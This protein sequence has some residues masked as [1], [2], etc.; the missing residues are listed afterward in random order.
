MLLD[1]SYTCP[2]CRGAF[3]KIEE[4]PEAN[5]EQSETGD[6]TASS[7]GLISRFKSVVCLNVYTLYKKIVGPPL[8][9]NV[10]EMNT[11]S[12]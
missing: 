12:A 5:I 4:E 6:D 7:E 1:F 8:S 3:M 2:M 10:I 9:N 11:M